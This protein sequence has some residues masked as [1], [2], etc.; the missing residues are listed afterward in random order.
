LERYPEDPRFLLARGSILEAQGTKDLEIV[1]PAERAA[2][3][4]SRREAA[5]QQVAASRGQM[6]EA[7]KCY[8]RA[9]TADPGLFEARVRLGHVLHSLGQPQEAVPELEGVIAEPGADPHV[10]YLAWLFLGA[11]REAAGRPRDAVT[12][13]QAAIR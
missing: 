2:R 12:A 8:R 1:S 5:W 6:K 7:E 4:Q 11:I 9:L 3:T 10:R 13:S